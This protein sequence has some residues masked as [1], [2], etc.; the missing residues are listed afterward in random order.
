VSTEFV[1]FRR[2]AAHSENSSQGSRSQRKFLPGKPL[3][4][5]E[6]G[7][8]HPHTVLA[9]GQS[10]SELVRLRFGPSKERRREERPGWA[11]PS[12]QSGN[13]DR[14]TCSKLFFFLDSRDQDKNLK[15]LIFNFFSDMTS[16]SYI[17]HHSRA[18][19]PLKPNQDREVK[20]YRGSYL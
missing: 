16:I 2:E 12:N 4:L 17:N 14:Q 19:S 5:T 11:S 18:P 20:I 1:D 9:R 3:I 15:F 7:R 8:P 6:S 13:L 10:A